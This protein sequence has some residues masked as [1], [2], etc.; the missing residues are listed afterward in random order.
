MGNGR[1]FPV[2]FPSRSGGEEIG[3]VGCLSLTPTERVSPVPRASRFAALAAVFFS[4]LAAWAPASAQVPIPLQE[5]VRLFNNLPAAQQQALIRELQRQLPPAQ[6]EA[7]IGMLQQQ[8]RPGTDESVEQLAVAPTPAEPS[9]DLEALFPKFS[10]GDTLVIEFEPREDDAAPTEFLERLEDGNPYRLDDSGR[11]YLPGVPAM[12]LAGLDVDQATIRVRA[13]RQLRPFDVVITRLPLDPIGTDALEPFGYDL[14]GDDVPSTFAPATDIPVPVDYVIGPG[15]TINIQLFGNESAEYFLTVS[16]DGT[17]TFPELGPVNVS[18]L[19]FTDL[20]NAINERV[21]EQMIGVR[22]STTLGELRSIRVFVLGDVSQPGSYTV[23]GLAT[24][25]NALFASGGVEEIGSLRRIAL[26]RNGATVTTLDLYDLLLRG[27]TS[28]DSRLEP[29]DV[30][31]VPPIG[32]TVAIDGEVRR[33]AI[34]E[35]RN[36]QNVGELIALAGGLNA[37]ANRADVK[38]ERIVP[39]R[40]IAVTDIDLTAA[41]AQQPVRDGDCCACNRTSNSS[42]TPCA[43]RATC[44]GPGSINGAPAWAGDLLS[45]PELVKPLSDLN[46]VLIRRENAPNVDVDVLSA[47]LE[48]IWRRRP[49]AVNVELQPRDTVYVFHLEIGRRQIVDQSSRARGPG[50]A[51]QADPHRAHRRPGAS[52]GRVSARARHARQRPAA[53]R[54]R[55]ERRG[56]CDRG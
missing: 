41:G 48:A 24:M 38:L 20:R 40:G 55:L 47:D 5:Q 29:G 12:E 56:L 37:M 15:D 32:A 8:D 53:R 31:F 54:R 1:C 45:S 35:I 52:G 26:L 30:I 4:S 14:F 25:T 46:Y 10:A 23:S 44:S 16:R 39:G 33:P 22:A 43:S 11:L 51:Q 27:D 36:E 42:R 6:R 3:T 49:G 18:G 2:Y 19:T 34:Y 9:L 17:V 13:E 28:G 21:S 50:C 7:I